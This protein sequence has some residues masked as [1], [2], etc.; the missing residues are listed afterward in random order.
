[1]RYILLITLLI[2]FDTCLAD[3]Q[4]LRSHNGKFPGIKSLMSVDELKASGLEKLSEAELSA[5][6]RWLVRYTAQDASSMKRNVA[7]IK[8]EANKDIHSHIKGVFTGWHGETKFYLQNGQVWQQRH[9]RS[10]KTRLSNPKVVISRNMF[11]F[12]EMK[13]LEANKAVAVKRLE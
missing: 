5:L 12:Y 11:G 6:N 13:I 2:H 8:K 7:E 1:M 9:N 10:W 3:T 4:S